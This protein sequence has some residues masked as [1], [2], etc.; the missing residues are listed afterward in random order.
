VTVGRLSRAGSLLA[1]A[2]LLAACAP[3][4]PPRSFPRPPSWGAGTRAPS[5]TAWRA[6]RA[7]L[8]AIQREA[9]TPRTLR[10]SLALREPVTG[11]TLEARGAVAIAPPDGLRMILL[12]PG[13]TTALDL[14]L[15]RDR[16]RFAVPAIDLLRR[17]DATTPRASM[18]GLPIDFLRW[19]ML[20]PA[21]GT[22]LWAERQGGG[23]R[24]LLRSGSAIIDLRVSDSGGIEARRAL[25][26]AGSAEE[27][28]RRIEEEAIGADRIGCAPVRYWQE[29]TGLSVTVR[30]EGEDLAA[31]NPK[32]F[33]DPDAELLD[34]AHGDERVEP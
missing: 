8:A 19:W 28:R 32:A 7:R 30:C 5:L 22:L 18:R 20:G 14:W 10:V 21:T 2:S 31:P 24:L 4:A 29:S 16:F 13:G 25:W 9:G 33:A 3:A 23:D 11:R 15:H 12:G 17:G 27:P 1:A 26:E 6:A 34:S